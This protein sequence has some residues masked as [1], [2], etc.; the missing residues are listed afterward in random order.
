MKN[1]RH[2]QHAVLAA[3]EWEPGVKAA[4]IGVI[5]N[6]DVVAL[7]GCVATAQEKSTAEG[8]ARHVTG[9]IA[10]D[11]GCQP[12][13]R[14]GPERFHDRRNC[15]KRVGVGQRRARWRSQGHRP[16]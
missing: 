14:R 16:E 2:L 12:G 8:M 10:N 1:D 6:Q 4:Q 7:R 15:G 9:A 3:L 13:W 11:L 5:V